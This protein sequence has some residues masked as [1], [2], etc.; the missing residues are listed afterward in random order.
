MSKSH[1]HANYNSKSDYDIKTH[2]ERE[3][4]K[5]RLD[6]YEW[7]EVAERYTPHLHYKMGTS[8]RKEFC[9]QRV[10]HRQALERILMWI[11]MVL[12]PN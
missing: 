5:V 3:Y 6:P 8:N 4:N 1:V 9:V 2:E 11:T 10:T 12:Q 7:T